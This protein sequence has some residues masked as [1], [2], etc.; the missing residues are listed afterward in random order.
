MEGARSLEVRWIFPG[1][2]E[3]AMAEWFDRFPATAELQEDA[4]IVDP[5]L[6]GLSVKVRG[7]RAF[8]VKT[9]R[10]SPGIL[11][12][13]GRARGRMESWQKWSF[14]VTPLSK[15]SEGPAGWRLV[16]KKRR[17][18]QFLVA[19]GQIRAVLAGRG[20]EP[21]CAVELTEVRLRGAAWWTLGFE[22]TGP[23]SLLHS[24]LEATAALVFA[25]DLPEGIELGTENSRSYVEWLRLPCR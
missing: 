15:V 3:A 16:H 6:P 4:Y 24:H 21:R 22:T 8:E 14:P 17:I 2:L 20:Q 5:H 23:T 25:L 19:G 1:Q 9:Y 7:G 12:A 10:G 13:A 18:S 11:E